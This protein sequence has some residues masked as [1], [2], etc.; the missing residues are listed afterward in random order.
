LASRSQQHFLK[1]ARLLST[2]KPPVFSALVTAGS[3]L[4]EASRIIVPPH[5]QSEAGRLTPNTGTN[6]AET[7]FPFSSS[8]PFSKVHGSF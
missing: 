3:R 1:A 2:R 6:D 7:P 8:Y 5:H 4:L